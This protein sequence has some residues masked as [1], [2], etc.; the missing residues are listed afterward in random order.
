MFH[1]GLQNNFNKT[2]NLLMQT[3]SLKDILTNIN[4][5]DW[6]SAIFSKEKYPFQL[7]TEIYLAS[8]E[9][10]DKEDPNIIKVEG[11]VLLYILG[12][13]IAQD[14]V[15]NAQQQ[16]PN[17][18]VEELIKAF[19]YYYKNDAFIEFDNNNLA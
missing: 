9:E 2:I 17:V 11:V 13:A 8:E 19:N 5:L 18:T 3:R 12:T 14:I 16:K 15:E 6:K 1:P 4:D 7:T 10:M